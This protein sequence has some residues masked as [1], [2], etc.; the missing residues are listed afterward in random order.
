MVQLILLAILVGKIVLLIWLLLF[1]RNNLDLKSS[2]WTD[3]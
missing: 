3:L 1:E 2:K